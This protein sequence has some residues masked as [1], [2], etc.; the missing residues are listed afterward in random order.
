MPF[1][2]GEDANGLGTLIQRYFLEGRFGPINESATSR[3]SGFRGR[4]SPGSIS[5]Q[6]TTGESVIS[7]ALAVN[8][9][10]SV[11]LSFFRAVSAVCRA[12]HAFQGPPQHLRMCAKREATTGGRGLN[13]PGC[14]R[15]RCQRSL[16]AGF[17]GPKSRTFG[18]VAAR[19]FEGTM[20]LSLRHSF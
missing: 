12:L 1:T 8:R 2:E 13:G 15:N 3:S 18:K 20:Q 5:S 4:R 6:P 9:T 16:T 7:K 17:D 10:D 19:T 11:R 14:F